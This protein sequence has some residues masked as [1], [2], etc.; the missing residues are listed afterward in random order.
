MTVKIL[1]PV[2]WM[3]AAFACAGGSGTGVPT[4]S[5]RL[6][7]KEK[8]SVEVQNQ[9]FYQ[10]TVYAYRAGNRARL[11]VVE[12]QSTRSFEFVWITGDLRFLIDFFANGCVLTDPLAVDRG[13]DL[14]LI[15]E[16]QD[17]RRASQ[18]LCR[19]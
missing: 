15:L 13:D 16:P 6:M 14:L 7:E 10:A 5:V 8:V 9:N 4:S 3:F 2:F 1:G 18:A 12:S 19:V 11:G 17:Y